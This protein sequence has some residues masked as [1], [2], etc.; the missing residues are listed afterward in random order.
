MIR[1][2]ALTSGKNLPASRFRIRQ[3]IAPL[4]ER[5]IEV[6]ERHLPFSKYV[7]SSNRGGA[8]LLTGTKVLGR[9]PGVAASRAADVTWLERELVPGRVTL[10]GLTGR[11]RLFDVDDALWMNGR[12]EFSERLAASCDGVIAGNEFLADHYRRVAR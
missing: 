3:F 7:T 1:V 2:V 8:R 5:G 4:A 9:L 12:P 10:E 6:Q 11:P